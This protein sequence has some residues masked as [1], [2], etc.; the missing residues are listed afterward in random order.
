MH[1]IQ[2]KIAEEG[3]QGKVILLERGAYDGLDACVMRV[4]VT[5]CTLNQLIKFDTGVTL[6]LVRNAAQV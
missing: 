5:I 2:N 4:N 3:G 6:L 1:G